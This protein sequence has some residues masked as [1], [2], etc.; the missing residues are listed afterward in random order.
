MLAP[1]RKRLHAVDGYYNFALWRKYPDLN[2]AG[3]NMDQLNVLHWV[4]LF[5]RGQLLDHLLADLDL[6]VALEGE[7]VEIEYTYSEKSGENPKETKLKFQNLGLFVCVVQRSRQCWDK[8]L[9]RA[10]FL[11][12]AQEILDLATLVCAEDW[13]QGVQPLV[14][15]VEAAFL[16]ASLAR[17]IDF[18]HLLLRVGSDTVK[19]V[20]RIEKLLT[21]AEWMYENHRSAERL[22]LNPQLKKVLPSFQADKARELAKVAFLARL[23][24]AEVRADLDRNE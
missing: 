17:R 13:K 11:L 24:P 3:V 22:D 14:T 8:I 2:K 9:P 10:S 6:G 15:L 16:K 7:H 23:K 21:F 5:D 19:D 18:V 1:Y 4:L 20:L 12:K